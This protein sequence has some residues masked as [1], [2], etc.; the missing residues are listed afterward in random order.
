MTVDDILEMLEDT[1]SDNPVLEE[2]LRYA[3]LG[4]HVVPIIPGDKR[5][6]MLEWQNH[7]TIDPHVIEEWWMK[8][9]VGYGVGIAPR[10]FSDGSWLFV[11]DVDDKDDKHGSEVL[12]ALEQEHGKLPDTWRVL[13]P[14]G[15]RHLY[16]RSPVEIRNDQSAKIGD[17][18]D[19][20][21]HGGQTCAP[22][23]VHENGR[24]YEWEIGYAPYDGV[25][26]ADAPMWLVDMLTAG[27]EPKESS[28]TTSDYT[29]TDSPADR[30]NAGTTWAELLEADGWTLSHVNTDGEQHW[31][32]PGK[33]KRDGTSATV[34]VHGKD[35]LHVF[36]TSV[37]YLDVEGNYSRFKYYAAR[38]HGGNMSDASKAIR[39]DERFY[40]VNIDKPEKQ[41][42][43]ASKPQFPEEVWQ[44]PVLQHIRQAAQA[45]TVSPHALLFH[46][47]A[48]VAA[49]T[50]PSYCVPPFRGSVA[51]FSLYVA[52]VG[53]PGSGKS[54]AAGLAD[55]LIGPAPLGTKRLALGTGEGIIEHY[56]RKTIEVDKDKK[57]TVVKRQDWHGI[58]YTLDE[59]SKLWQILERNGQTTLERLRT[60]WL[61]NPDGDSNSTA[62]TSRDLQAGSYALGLVILLQPHFAH[63]LFDD[64]KGGLPQ[65]LLFCYGGDANPPEIDEQ[66]DFP[67]PLEWEPK[68]RNKPGNNIEHHPLNYPDDIRREI[69]P[70]ARK[71]LIREAGVDVDDSDE[72]EVDELDKH[73][74]VHRLKLAGLLALLEQRT[75]V[76]LDDWK[77]ADVL[78]TYS[79][80]VRNTINAQ[81][82]AEL[83]QRE[84]ARN[85]QVAQRAVIVEEATERRAFESA[86]RAIVRRVNR[87][88]DQPVKRRDLQ[89]AVA[90][91]DRHAV[92]LDEVIDEAV[93]RQQLVRL[94]DGTFK[95]GKTL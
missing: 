27:R 77:L 16:F 15:G 39:A 71:A 19:I 32:R 24:R 63:P 73:R 7:A 87:A 65:R 22:P 54:N 52:H 34:G 13:S 6:P 74:P 45:R 61:G 81:R 50:P 56:F 29:P 60:A 72:P 40:P 38:H 58:L 23:T 84:Q 94:H 86:L 57:K 3:S 12:H 70:N 11:L 62:E 64:E 1:P 93:R 88:G 35:I 67:G 21:G 42:K 5:P 90:A 92:T 48:R 89:Q 30:Y 46:V 82:L 17:G 2:A 20:R 25:E 47:L 43:P 9:Y 18:L 79:D 26:L 68:R 49:Y 78:L 59:G 53:P 44:R 95:K 4:L 66:P 36:T 80:N 33:N 37:P 14:S 51:P 69:L 31:T 76:T 85:R 10:Q 28:R 91:R 83:R 8:R 55:E 75:D 41:W